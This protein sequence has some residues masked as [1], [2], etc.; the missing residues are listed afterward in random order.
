MGIG[1]G[2]SIIIF[3]IS[4]M[5]MPGLY[6]TVADL[7]QRAASLGMSLSVTSGLGAIP[8]AF[9]IIAVIGGC[10]ALRRIKWGLALTGSILA[11]PIGIPLGII[12]TVFLAQSQSEFK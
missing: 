3:G 11:I 12:S 6:D 1:G 7:I 2:I 8:L 4:L 9:G 5:D 10:H